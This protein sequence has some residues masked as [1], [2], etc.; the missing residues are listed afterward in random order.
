MI[1]IL[2]DKTATS[3][4]TNGLG[5]LADCIRCIVTEERN[6]IYECEFDYPVTGPYFNDIQ[7]GRIIVSTHDEQGDVQPFDI[8]AKSE[9]INGV[10]TFNAH[11]ISYRLNEITVKPFTAGS[12]AEALSKIDS[13]SVTTNPFTFWT[14][15]SVTAT[16]V[17][18]TP[19]KARAMLGGE[20]NSILDVYGTGEYEFDKFDVKLYLHRG[21]DTNVSIRYGKNLID[22]TNQY[23]AGDTYTAVVPFWLGDETVDDETVTTLV[24]LPE[25]ILS[26]GQSVPS[27]REV[28]VPMDLSSEFSEKPSVSDLRTKAQ[29]RLSSSDAWLPNQTVTINF[30][31]LWQTEE[32]KD[33]APL[34]R[35]RLC[36]TCGVFVPMYG[37]SLRAKVI[38]VV[39]NVLLDRYDE[40]ELG[41]KPTTYTAVLE[42]IYDSKVAGVQQ[43]FQAIKVDI[44]TVEQ[45]AKSY[46]DSGISALRTDLEGQID[47]KIETWAQSSNPATS[48]TTAEIRA[49]HNGDLWLYTGTS[50]ITV[51]SVTIKP[52]GVYQYNG[53]TGVWAAYSSTTNNLFD[54]VDGKTT[55]FYG[56]PTGTYSNKQTGDYLVDSSTGITYRWSGSAW[57]KQTDYKAYT[58]SGISALRTDLEGQIDAK[59]ETWAQSSNPATSW[60]TAEI[61]AEHN[62]DLWLYTGTSSIT[63]GSVTIKP[64]G[65]YQYNGS[66]GVWAAYSSTTNNLFD[67]VDGKTT[68]FYGSP[69][70]TYSNKQTGD[71]LVDSSTG[72]TYRWSGSAW[73][74]QTDYKA[75]TDG[76]ITTAKQTIESEYEQA[77]ED[78]TEL[79]R[80]GTGGYIV[81]TVNADGQPIELLITDNID[82]N[83]AV[84]IW[85]WN[86]GGLAHSHT[87]YNG[88]FNDVAITQDGK[89]NATMITTGILTANLIKAGILSDANSNVVFD[90]DAGTLAITRGSIN[91]GNGNFIATDAGRLIAIGGGEIRDPNSNTV[92]NLDTG[93]LT[94]KK[95]SINLGNGKFIATDAGVLTALGG[96]NIQDVAGNNYWNL[97][98]GVFSTKNGYIG[99]F[100]IGSGNL[101]YQS[102]ARYVVVSK[103]EITYASSYTDN[104]RRGTT[105][106]ANRLS[107]KDRSDESSWSMSERAYI[108]FAR[109]GPYMEFNAN[110]GMR[111]FINSTVRMTIEPN[112]PQVY[113]NGTIGT[114]GAKPRVIDTDNYNTKMLYCYEMPSPM[115]GDIGEAILDEEGVC[116]V[117][118]DDIFTETIIE[119]I[120]Y[121]VFLQKEGEGDCWVADKHP[122]YFVIQGTP[123]LKVAWELKARQINYETTRFGDFKSPLEEYV[124]NQDEYFDDDYI[125]EQ[126]A[127]L[128][129]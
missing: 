14:N 28:I 120:E 48:W 103:D 76:A 35:L 17:S 64:Q 3:F 80:G 95:G 78:A 62:G 70:G 114:S 2:F 128:Y 91:L 87:G 42:K 19:R 93:L 46:A 39:Y 54:L 38:K 68:I 118:L 37:M 69:T 125:N 72:I 73:V 12:C 74:K 85:R 75:Y 101:T 55:I 31:Q 44:Q 22:M 11:H 83:Q 34:Q 117:D 63:V 10:V 104:S 88:P 50:S 79:I 84:N 124:Y 82:I 33:F 89:I 8:Y 21:Q 26:S 100:S 113:V 57:V 29:S 30:V 67:L 23:D 1:P 102:T 122:R 59:I 121:Q 47:A 4:T 90:L 9:P 13:Q 81:T 108:L 126:E 27:G 16:F 116:Y 45:N 97:T 65:V 36:D 24:T 53:S 41:D 94:M 119:K 77:I 49:E 43:G 127:L 112:S 52:Q 96:G 60:T 110:G 92:L 6:G 98:S 58:D 106:G 105:L 20:E 123:N 56:S 115:F 107:F 111:F 86:L 7:I 32:Y 40:M 109:S 129:G 61:R 71:Y 25:W 66:T 18:E 99:D 51:G 5:R 15:K